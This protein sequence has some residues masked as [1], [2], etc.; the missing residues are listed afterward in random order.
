MKPIP[1]YLKRRISAA[2]ILAVLAIL[3]SLSSASFS[4]SAKRLSEPVET[5]EFS[6]TFGTRFV[7]KGETLGLKKA[8][9]DQV[10]T[11]GKDVTVKTQVSQVCQA[12]GC[13]FIASEDEFFARVT[14]QDYSFFVP[15]DIAGK[16]VLLNAKLTPREL[17]AEQVSHLKKDLGEGGAIAQGPTCELTAQSV[18]VLN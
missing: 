14:F 5:D 2:G 9:Q 4:G 1:K 10:C 13:F 6:E 3:L 16:D 7:V 12:K 15:T 11:E 17:S 18:R 8:M